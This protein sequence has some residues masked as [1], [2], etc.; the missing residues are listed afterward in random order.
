MPVA[1]L[2]TECQVVPSKEEAHRAIEAGGIYLNNCTVANAGA[3][4]TFEDV[5]D[6]QFLV[7]QRCQNNYFLV[8]ITE[9]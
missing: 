5:I 2:W 6:R 4:V 7:L 3:K 1:D 9:T 8:R